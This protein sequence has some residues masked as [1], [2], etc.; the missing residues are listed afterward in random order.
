MKWWKSDEDDWHSRFYRD[1]E[2]V[3][4]DTVMK[5]GDVRTGDRGDTHQSSPVVRSCDT[6]QWLVTLTLTLTLTLALKLTLTLTSGDDHDLFWSDMIGCCN[7]WGR[8]IMIMNW[9]IHGFIESWSH[10]RSWS[11]WWSSSSSWHITG[12]LFVLVLRCAPEPCWEVGVMAE[13]VLDL[14][15][16][17]L[18]LIWKTMNLVYFNLGWGPRGSYHGLSP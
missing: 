18:E 2:Q 12:G 1:P 6:D 9:Q 17:L 13:R 7:V 14:I 10:G 4:Y 15:W 11:W 5:W 8:M 16:N 3:G